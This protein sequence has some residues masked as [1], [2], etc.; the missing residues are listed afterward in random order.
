MV[1]EWFT[2]VRAGLM[3]PC[4]TF[5]S[6]PLARPQRN[7][8]I[9]GGV[10]DATGPGSSVPRNPIAIVAIELQ[11]KGLRPEHEQVRTEEVI[12]CK[13]GSF[14]E[15]LGSFRVRQ[16]P[17]GRRQYPKLDC[18]IAAPDGWLRGWSIGAVTQLQ[19]CHQLPLE[20]STMRWAE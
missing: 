3:H 19:R 8:T 13:R 1:P 2:I 9:I 11:S 18:S 12:T 16:G 20:K 10:C 7:W 17:G 5:V 15:L 4:L 14:D 6:R